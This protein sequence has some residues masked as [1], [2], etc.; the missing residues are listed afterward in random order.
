MSKN[1][2]VIYHGNCDDGFGAAYAAW[3]F[4]G[5]NAEYIPGEYGLTKEFPFDKID[6]DGKDV[7]ILDFSYDKKSMEDLQKRARYV[8]LIDHHKSAYDSLGDMS[9]C[10][11]DMSHSGA[12]LAWKNFHP[13]KPVPLMIEY[14]QDRDLWTKKF[15]DT[16]FFTMGIRMYPMSFE[17]WSK[18]EDSEGEDFKRLIETGKILRAN[19]NVQMDTIIE[20]GATPIKIG[21]VIGTLIN[22]PSIFVSDVGSLLSSKTDS[23]AILWSEG[24]DGR[25][26]CGFRSADNFNVLPVATLLGGGGHPQACATKFTSYANFKTAIANLENANIEDF[27]KLKKKTLKP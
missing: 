23:F 13:K 18:F 9:C 7:I 8:R 2:V 5:D 10:E 27:G 22:C 17:T 15:E 21:G 16:E 20:K 4:F 26:S 3:K 25:I 19:M 6:I 11:F 14:I 1:T 24:K 12:Y